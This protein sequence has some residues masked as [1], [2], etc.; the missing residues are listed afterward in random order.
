MLKLFWVGLSGGS[1]DRRLVGAK[2]HADISPGIPQG[3]E[4]ETSTIFPEFPQGNYEEI[5]AGMILW[6]SPINLCG[7]LGDVDGLPAGNVWY[8]MWSV[9]MDGNGLKLQSALN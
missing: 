8:C 1:Y 3:T 2:F 5:S 9:C 7:N 6:N 4:A